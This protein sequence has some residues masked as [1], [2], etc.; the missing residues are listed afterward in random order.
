MLDAGAPIDGFGVGSSLAVSTETPVLDTVYNRV[1]FEE[2]P[3]RKD[4]GGQ[5]HLAGAQ[6]GLA[7]RGVRD[8]A[9]E[10]GPVGGVALGEVM[11]DWTADR[12][13]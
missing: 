13:R 5:G 2:R 4:V 11:L 7:L 9:D 3:V 1:A 8:L 10:E 12:R 6:A